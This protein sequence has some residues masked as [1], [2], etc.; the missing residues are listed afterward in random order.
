[1]KTNESSQAKRK[2]IKLWLE[3][4]DKDKL[5]SI[6]VKCV[7]DLIYSDSVRF[8]LDSKV[9]YWEY[10]GNNLDGSEPE[11]EEI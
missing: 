8:P 7:E 11:P 2:R 5:I 10:T 4:L 3:G 6:T 9:P 1:M